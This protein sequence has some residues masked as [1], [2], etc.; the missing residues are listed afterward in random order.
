M[1]EYFIVEHPTRGC[2]VG[3]D[4]DYR[5]G[6]Q[7]KIYRCRWSILRTDPQVTVFYNQQEAEDVAKEIRGSHVMRVKTNPLSIERA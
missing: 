2:Y 7:I 6:K 1:N 5:Q 3:Y 4:W